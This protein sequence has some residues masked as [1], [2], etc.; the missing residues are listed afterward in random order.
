MYGV[1]MSAEK[2]FEVFKKIQVH[3]DTLE[4]AA[5]ETRET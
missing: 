5:E 1:I 3:I 2:V 4:K